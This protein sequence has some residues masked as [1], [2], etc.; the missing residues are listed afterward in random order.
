MNLTDNKNNDSPGVPVIRIVDDDA[1]M[2]SS[3]VFLL[4][5]EH[6][7]VRA[8]TNALEFLEK[9]DPEDTGCLLLDVRMPAMSGLELQELMSLKEIDLPIVFVSGHGDIDMVVRALKHGACDFLQKPVDEV[10]LLNALDAAIEKDRQHRAEV[11]EVRTL[12][13]RY[14]TLTAREKEVV[15]L[16]GQGLMNKVVADHMG[17]S[18][19]TVQ[20]HRGVAMKKLRARSVVDLVKILQGLGI[21]V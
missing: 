18:E 20:I 3:W 8:Y 5:G 7:T 9:D 10:R 16:V 11:R 2:L 15:G 14:D 6:R 21:H 4:E 13:E 12:E 1:M 19:R 17:I